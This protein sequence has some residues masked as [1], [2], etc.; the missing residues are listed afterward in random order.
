[1]SKEQ[2]EQKETEKRI[3]E[4]LRSYHTYKAAITNLQSGIDSILP[5]VTAKYVYREGTAGVF[6]I[7]STENNRV[8]DRVESWRILHLSEQI[9]RYEKLVS[10]IEVGFSVLTE[11]QV[12]FLHQRYFLG[13]SYADIAKKSGSSES[14]IYTLRK[15]VL[16][17]LRISLSNLLN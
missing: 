16:D 15:T 2:N 6:E 7:V 13:L 17:S 11:E 14:Y 8:L 9:A 3:E 5:G 10:S 12:R 4:H 1:M